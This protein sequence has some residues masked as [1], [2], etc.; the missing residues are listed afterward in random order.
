MAKDYKHT[1]APKEPDPPAP[2]WI[3]LLAGFALGF[4]AA[5]VLKVGVGGS[6]PPAQSQTTPAETKPAADAQESNGLRFDFYKMLPNFEVVIPEQDKDV[7]HAGEIAA[8]DTPGTYVLQAGSFK[9]FGDA[10]RLKATL[11]LLGIESTIQ[12]VTIDN[13]QTW[14]RVRIGP[15]DDLDTL[16]DIR[17]RLDDSDIQA[18]VIRVGD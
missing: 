15:H 9:N 2:G 14:H 11:A 6:Q 16:N 13:D 10:D 3:W 4:A 8:V 7:R 17:D 18:L 5:A 1:A 12:R